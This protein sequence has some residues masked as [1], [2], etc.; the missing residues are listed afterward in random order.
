MRADTDR[1]VASAPTATA[2]A[3]APTPALDVTALRRDLI[4]ELMR[5]VRAD[6]ERG[7]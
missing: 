1:T 6:F 3:A 4:D 5:R 7:A 2:T